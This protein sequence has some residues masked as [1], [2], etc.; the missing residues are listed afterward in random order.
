[1]RDERKILLINYYWPPCGGSAVQ[2][3]LDLTNNFAK[4]GIIS[5]VI[6]IDE[7]IATFPF[8]DPQL[9]DRIADSTQVFRTGSSELFYIYD[10][11][12]GRVTQ[13]ERQLNIDITDQKFTQKIA[14]FVR[15]NF[16]I[17]DP[18]RGWNKH[19]LKQAEVLLGANH[20]DAVFTAG[21]PQSSH[22]I[23]LALKKKYPAIKWVA[24]FHDYWTDNFNQ[25]QFYRTAPAKWID[26]HYEKDVLR[27]A[28]WI[29]THCSSSKKLLSGKVKATGDKILIH[30]MGYNGALFGD[31]SYKWKKQDTFVIAYTGILAATYRPEPF[32]EAVHKLI[33]CY[34]EIPIKM[35][36]AGA[37]SNDIEEKIKLCGIENNFDFLG[38]VSQKES[39]ELLKNATILFLCNP[40]IGN[41]RLIVPGKIY[42]YLAVEKPIV[43]LSSPESENEQL[44]ETFKAGKNFEWHQTEEIFHYLNSLMTIWKDKKNL[45][46]PD[47]ENVNQFE[48]ENESKALLKK[49][50]LK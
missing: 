43:S 30:R 50:H 15:G 16:L 11:L 13:K 12:F 9:I 34:P 1:M 31:K 28:D 21:P 49:L 48:R 29:M 47:N 7:N 33:R 23:G 39:V 17:P 35:K 40:K 26:R 32:I 6:T 3:W 20:Y 37:L 8:R 2:R 41:D 42:E 14:R 25:K 22:L 38:Y 10:K 19:A 27:R 36:L 46:L 24:D 44:I 4:E 45:D 18:R 5:D